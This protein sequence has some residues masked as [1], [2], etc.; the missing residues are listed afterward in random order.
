[1]FNGTQNFRLLKQ[2]V[3]GSLYLGMGVLISG[4][5]MIDRDYER[6]DLYTGSVYKFAHSNHPIVVDRG[7]L[8]MAISVGPKDVKMTPHKRDELRMFLHYYRDQGAGYLKVQMP[9]HA[10]SQKAIENVVLGMQR[11]LE[12]MSIGPESVRVSKYVSRDAYPV[13]RL[14]YERHVAH[15]PKCD[16]WNEN[17][18][19]DENNGNSDYWGCATQN[20]LA[21]MVANP[22]D[23][24]GPRGWSPR[25]AR[26]RD[27]VWEKFIKGESTGAQRSQDERVDVS[28]MKQ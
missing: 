16:G 22:R 21:A 20:N 19:Q 7:A 2:A 8:S 12:G 25:D 6:K 3:V 4:C 9:R 26:R 18:G 10:S 24:K 27:K 14:S 23:L 13:I 17:L 15:G 11:E 28:G 5:R 1:M